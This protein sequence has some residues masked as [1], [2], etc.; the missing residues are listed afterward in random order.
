MD[1]LKTVIARS[2]SDEAIPFYETAVSSRSK[3]TPHSDICFFALFLL[4][5]KRYQGIQS[6]PRAV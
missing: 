1:F 2:V 5:S 6:E 4:S 3:R